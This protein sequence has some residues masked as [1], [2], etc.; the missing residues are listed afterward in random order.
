MEN[1]VP[2]LYVRNYVM[3]TSVEVAIKKVT[4]GQ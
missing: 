4:L 2:V 3:D 1:I